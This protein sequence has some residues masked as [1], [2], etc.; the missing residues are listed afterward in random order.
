[1]FKY[2]IMI[3]AWCCVMAIYWSFQ[4]RT[5]FYTPPIEKTHVS[6]DDDTIIM[7]KYIAPVG[8]VSIVPGWVEY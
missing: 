2:V 3:C 6:K 4:D 1:M 7:P 8:G 5:P